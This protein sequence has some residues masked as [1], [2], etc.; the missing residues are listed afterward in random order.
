MYILDKPI[1]DVDVF[2]A[3]MQNL[4]YN[5]VSKNFLTKT[6]DNVEVNITKRDNTVNSITAYQ[7]ND[8]IEIPSSILTQ[9]EQDIASSL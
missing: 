3:N 9:V 4:G 8:I 1:N 2:D 6:F 7:D 5:A